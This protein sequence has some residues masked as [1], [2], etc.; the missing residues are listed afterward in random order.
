MSHV[1][2]I[3]WILFG[4][5]IT[6]PSFIIV[7]YVWRIL[8]RGTFWPPPRPWAAPKRPILNRV[9]T[10]LFCT[11]ISSNCVSGNFL[12]GEESSLFSFK[13]L[14]LTSFSLV[15][16]HVHFFPP[17][18][19]GLPISWMIFS[20]H[21]LS[22]AYYSFSLN[23]I[24]ALYCLQ[25]QFLISCFNRVIFEDITIPEYNLHNNIS[26]RHSLVIIE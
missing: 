10:Y 9:K 1:S 3:F 12:F 11:F 26:S 13:D 5:G 21:H 20:I 24:F 16:Q 22:L 7:G 14:T 8:W 18:T 2:Y 17:T 4:L 6:V 23:F 25:S 19:G 15:K